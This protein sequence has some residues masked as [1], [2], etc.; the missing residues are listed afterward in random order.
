MVYGRSLRAQAYGTGGAQRISVAPKGGDH[1][2]RRAGKRRTKK[3][4][5]NQKSR[6][7]FTLVESIALAYEYTHFSWPRTRIFDPS[8]W[9]SRQIVLLS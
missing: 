3:R 4:R 2:P 8:D 1:A 9:K 7:P 6:K 5:F